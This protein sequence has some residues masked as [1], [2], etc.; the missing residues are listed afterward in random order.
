MRDT[1]TIG[2][3]AGC[4]ASVIMTVII[5]IVRGLGF[6][7]ITTW[8]TAA[9]IFLNM[10]LIHTPVGYFIGFLGQFILGASFGVAVAFALRFTGKDYYIL[11]GIG[12][13]A[14]Y[15]IGTVGFF[16]HLLH[17]QLQGRGDPLSN[18]MAVLEFNVLG[19][20]DSFIIAR[21][22]DFRKVK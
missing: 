5:L 16:M 14:M 9:A 22:G 19:I 10:G 3:I 11:K 6:Q 4:I 1:I 17:I 7:F 18:I 12:V 2:S 20:I 8:E 15:W 13:G 21:Y